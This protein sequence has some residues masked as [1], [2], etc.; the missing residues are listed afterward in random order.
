MTVRPNTLAAHRLIHRAQQLELSTGVLVD[1]L[2]RAHFVDGLNIGDPDTLDAIAAAIGMHDTRDWLAGDEAIDAVRGLDEKVRSLGVSGV[3]F[4]SSTDR[5]RFR[6]AARSGP[7]RGPRAQPRSGT[8]F[9]NVRHAAWRLE[10]DEDLRRGLEARLGGEDYAAGWVVAVVGSL[11]EARLRCG[12]A[13]VHAGG[14][15]AGAGVAVGHA[16]RTVCIYMPR[17]PTTADGCAAA[18]SAMDAG[19]APR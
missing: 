14:R 1:E 2:F 15:S 16:R 18:T 11:C 13:R 3:P 8:R 17:W 19:C 9:V 10:P 7:A 6:G 4:S 12:P 5:L